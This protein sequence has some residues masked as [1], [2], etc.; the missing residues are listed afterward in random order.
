M[1][2]PLRFL[3]LDHRD[4]WSA[5]TTYHNIRPEALHS[6]FKRSDPYFVYVVGAGRPIHLSLILFEEIVQCL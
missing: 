1:L 2:I 5:S 4:C 6:V 3:S